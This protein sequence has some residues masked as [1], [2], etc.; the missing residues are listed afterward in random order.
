MLLLT[1]PGTKKV[2]ILKTPILLTFLLLAPVFG[3]FSQ[4]FTDDLSKANEYFNVKKYRE[5]LHVYYKIE[6]R[7]L[8]IKEKIASTH[9]LLFEY[10]EAAKVFENIISDKKISPESI[11][12]CAHVYRVMKKYKE[13]KTLYE[14]Y[15]SRVP[16]SK[17]EIKPYINSCDWA[18][19]NIANAPRYTVEE[20]NV[21]IGGISL[22]L[23]PYEN[24][25][26]YSV[27][28]SDDYLSNTVYYELAYSEIKKEKAKKPSTLFGGGDFYEGTPSI[29][30][31]GKYIYFS[32]NASKASTYT[33]KR[34]ENLGLSSS[35]VNILKIYRGE[36]KRNKWTNIIELPINHD[37]YSTTH[38]FITPEGKTLFF[39]SNR[40][41]G[42]GG[43][44]IY[45]SVFSNGK[46]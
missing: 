38:P 21:D 1:A 5:A 23:V 10:E 9:Y 15:L 36:K 16:E 7:T 29:T 11:L 14:N 8:E 27:P 2:S 25:I 32:R 42:Q 45:M 35:G 6:P 31:D 17:G 26:I 39:T 4:E 24:G 41:G 20:L 33:E 18:M 30:A 28:K 22:G 37:E 3:A 19:N 12:K 34:K 40:P 46:W 44:D 43:Y 13:A